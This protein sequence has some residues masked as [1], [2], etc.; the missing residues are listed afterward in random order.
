M[1]IDIKLV[2][3]IDN[4][5]IILSYIK[6]WPEECCIITKGRGPG[7]MP[8]PKWYLNT[9]INLKYVTIATGID[10]YKSILRWLFLA[11][12]NVLIFLR[13]GPKPQNFVPTIISYKHYNTIEYY[14]LSTLYHFLVQIAK[15][16]TRK[17]YFK[18]KSQKNVPANN[19]WH[20][21][22]VD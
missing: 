15:F 14:N 21:L 17:R 10:L 18:P 9:T 3:E 16:S 20:H 22:K 7:N 4:I 11:G 2:V 12:T 8:H 5:N 13:I 1:Y 6:L 19:C